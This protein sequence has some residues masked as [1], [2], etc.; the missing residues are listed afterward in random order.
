MLVF[1]ILFNLFVLA[2]LALD[3]GVLNR[4]PS[5]VGVRQALAWSAIWIMLAAIFAL[6]VLS[7]FGRPKH[8]NS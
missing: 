8:C 5:R 1:W 7:R 4:K 6:L 2:M 3:L